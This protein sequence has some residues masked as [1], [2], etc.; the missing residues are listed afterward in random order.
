MAEI[1]AAIAPEQRSTRLR[2]PKKRRSILTKKS[3]KES[4]L[5]CMSAYAN[6]L[7]AEE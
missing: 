1:G 6:T 3:S 7:Q 4:P 5:V 2:L